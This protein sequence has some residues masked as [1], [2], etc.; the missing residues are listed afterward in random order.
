[1]KHIKKVVTL[2]LA[3]AMVLAMSATVFAAGNGD[4]T[5]TTVTDPASKG[6]GAFTIT[7]ESAE[8]GHTFKAYRIFDGSVATINSQVKLGD[9]SWATGFNTGARTVG[10]ESKTLAQDQR[11][12]NEIQVL[13]FGGN[14]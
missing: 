7:M 9:I 11:F 5:S 6:S 8:D 3:F 1:M 10:E 14:V 13:D 2:F 4:K 12:S